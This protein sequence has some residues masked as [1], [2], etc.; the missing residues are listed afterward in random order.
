MILP[1]TIVV[2]V[3]ALL[4]ALVCLGF[5]IAKRGPNDYQLGAL[6]LLELLLIAQA[7]IAIVAPFVGNPPTGNP[8]EFGAY[9]L[10][11]ILI[12]VLAVFWALRERDRWSSVVLGVAA[13]AIAVMLWRMQLI[14]TV[15]AG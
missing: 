9:A 7:V 4:A 1:F 11:A 13:L 15:Q 14:W 5:A 10:A 2:I 6:A 8:V 3:V 12:P